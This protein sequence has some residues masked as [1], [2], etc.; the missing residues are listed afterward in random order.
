MTKNIR[1]A[2]VLVGTIAFAIMGVTYLL[3]WLMGWGTIWILDTHRN[4]FYGGLFNREFKMSVMIF[5]FARMLIILCLPLILAFRFP[6]K[7]NPYTMV[8]AIFIDRLLLYIMGMY[9]GAQI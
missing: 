3:G 9:K 6:G 8:A 2:I 5:Y 7:V 1:T 4:K